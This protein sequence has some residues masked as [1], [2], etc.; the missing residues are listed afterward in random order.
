MGALIEPN[1][2]AEAKDFLLPS[3]AESGFAVVDAQFKTEAWSGH[4]IAD[5]IRSRLEPI[6][7]LRMSGGHPDAIL[8]P[9]KPGTY[10]GEI[11]NAVTTL[12]L[13][14]IEAKGETEHNNQNSTRVAIT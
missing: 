11:E 13:A 1:V 4:P 8:V 9:P 14:V 3:D 10:R 2:L 6:N 5:S 7:S 12:P